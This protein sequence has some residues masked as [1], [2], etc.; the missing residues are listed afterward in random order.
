MSH[1]GM[2]WGILGMVAVV[3][4]L[5][6]FLNLSP[7]AR[8]RRRLRRTHSRIISKAQQPSVKLSVKTPKD[9]P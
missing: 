1:D 7:N 5:G 9:E 8:L 6:L 3:G 4:L 2:V